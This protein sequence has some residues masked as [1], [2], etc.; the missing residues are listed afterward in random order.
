MESKL[1]KLY[2]YAI[3]ALILSIFG[4]SYFQM[5]SQHWSAHFDADW[6]NIYNILLLK[7]GYV[8]E[9]YDHPAFTLFFINSIFLQVY[10]LFDQNLYFNLKEINNNLNL[11]VYF[12]KVFYIARLTNAL[13]HCGSIYLI[14]IILSKLTSNKIVNILLILAFTFSN[15]FFDNLFQIRPEI[16]SVFFILYSFYLMIRFI[17]KKNSLHLIFFSGLLMG[18][19]FISKIQIIFF[20]FFII[21]NI[22]LLK[23]YPLV[24]NNIRNNFELKSQTF[25]VSLYLY[26]IISLTYILIE[27]FIIYNH[28]RY[29]DHPKI[30]LYGFIF[31]NL[32]YLIYAK[33]LSN[34]S[35]LEFKFNILSYIIFV[36]G[37]LTT[38]LLL[39][40][41]DIVKIGPVNHNLYFKFLNPYYFLSNRSFDGSTLELLINFFNLKVIIEKKLLLFSIILFVPF[42]KEIYK[43]KFFYLIIAFGLL[44]FT[45]F[46]NNLRYFPLYEVYTFIAFL[47]FYALS[48]KKNLFYFRGFLTSL[49]LILSISNTFYIND[50]S[51]YFSRP[52]YFE[53]CKNENWI[54]LKSKNGLKN[55]TPWT[56][57]FDEKFY[58]KICLDINRTPLAKKFGAIRETR[59]LMS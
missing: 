32:F 18:L 36:F 59:T 54:L 7:S 27:Y 8:Q 25:K 14:H 29:I 58:K 10:D 12:E 57:K 39:F 43:L 45:I 13:F 40:I 21:L 31:F 37:F 50:F 35:K 19:A 26:L 24:I 56:K 38:I 22:P 2:N 34:N 55:W 49:I 44:L 42:L 15:Y 4:I 41:V 23:Y 5:V 9:Y 48:D 53:N 3:F 46:S 17:E 11:D 30:D 47:F 1:L 20:I 28:E 51:N 6:F 33:I 16:I 52:S